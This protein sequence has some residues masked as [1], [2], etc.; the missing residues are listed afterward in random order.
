MTAVKFDW[1]RWPDDEYRGWL[2]RA[3]GLFSD[4]LWAEP[5]AA[6]LGA[7]PLYGFHPERREGVCVQ[8][9]RHFGLAVGYAGL[10]ISPG[11]L[12]DA[13]CRNQVIVP[14]VHLTRF[15]LSCLQPSGSLSSNEHAKELPETV[16]R[17]LG[18]WPQR[19]ARKLKKDRAFASRSKIAV[20][21]LHAKHAGAVE[22]LYRDTVVRHRGSLRYHEEYF[23]A[24]V[25]LS[26][27]TSKVL[28]RG[29]FDESGRLAGFAMF[30]IDGATAHYLHGGV[31][32]SARSQGVSDLLLGDAIDRVIELGGESV[33][34]LP[35]PERQPGLIAFK[36]KWG[37]MDGLWTSLDRSNGILGEAAHLGMNLMAKLRCNVPA[38]SGAIDKSE[39]R[40]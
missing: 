18:S 25:A 8:I 6:A 39:A 16:I 13:E 11:W 23:R 5:I 15:N 33:T 28:A 30:G 17:C 37:E 10:P 34:L 19:N 2:A 40:A 24:I 14:G 1:K 36:R 20:G 27:R 7:Q 29:A 26:T 32:A 35:S 12:S 4:P 38:R 21:A 31:A 3:D 9:F 22:V